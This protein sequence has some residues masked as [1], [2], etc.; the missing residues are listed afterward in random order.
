MQT[1]FTRFLSVK[2]CPYTQN[3][4]NL[5]ELRRAKLRPLAKTLEVS[6]EGTKN[7]MLGLII[8]KLKAIEAPSELSDL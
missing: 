7:E 4:T 6:S 5:A 2:D 1:T 8:G 3:G